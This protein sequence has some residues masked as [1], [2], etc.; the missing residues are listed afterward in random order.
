[1]TID[2]PPL[3]EPAALRLRRVPPVLRARDFHLYT[4]GG[5]RLV[6]LWQYGGAAVLGHTPRS[7]LRELKNSA[8][9]GLYA[10]VPH[11]LENRLT[12]ALSRLFP[13]ASCRVYGDEASLRRALARAGFASAAAAPFPDPAAGSGLSEVLSLW[14]PFLKIEKKAPSLFLVP[15]LPWVLAP[16]VV[17][18]EQTAQAPGFPPSD[19]ISP[20]LL[21]GTC[22]AIQ[23]LFLWP[24][25]GQGN[26]PQ[27]RRAPGI[28]HQQGIY[29]HHGKALDEGVYTELFLRFLAG[30]FL[31]PPEQKE[32]LILPGY[33]SKG[34]EAKLAALLQAPLG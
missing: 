14:R 34:E 30:G 33:M 21:A 9:R 1:M 8:E 28:W 32:P 13:G 31:L 4:Q 18:F 22:R 12:K 17:V 16:R 3:P 19:L 6:D 10:P 2:E 29:L 20:V 15:V 7:V 27:I 11:P 26:F 24:E 25:R 23:D 5:R